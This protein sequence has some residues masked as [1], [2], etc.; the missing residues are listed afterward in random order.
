[1]VDENTGYI[2]VNKFGRSTHAEFLTSLVKLRDSGAEKFI[3]DLRGNGGGFMEMAI[4]MANEFLPAGSPIVSTHGRIPSSESIT[5]AD[6]TGAFQQSEVIVLMD[7]YS[8]SASEILAGAIQDNDRGLIIGRRSFGKGLVQRQI[9][10]PDSSALRLTTA[11]YHTPSGRCIQKTYT[12]GNLDSYSLEIIDRYNH[13]E[14]FNADS[15]RL[16]T[17]Q[18]FHTLHGRMVY[19]GGGIMPDVYVPNDTAGISSCLLYTSPS[20]RDRG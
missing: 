5:M 18:T 11:R 1:M 15:V 19:G 2:K 17:T 14:G 7:E 10:L 13:G 20:P 8:A 4:L 6:G 3:I 9:E 12:R 16:D